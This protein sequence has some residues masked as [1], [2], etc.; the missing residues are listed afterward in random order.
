MKTIDIYYTRCFIR[1]HLTRNVPEKWSELSPRQFLT[2]ASLYRNQTADKRFF[3]RFLSL[4]GRALDM[5]DYLLYKL[6]ELCEFVNDIRKPFDRFYLHR[7]GNGLYEF[8]GKATWNGY[9]SILSVEAGVLPEFAVNA[10]LYVSDKKVE[11][12]YEF[13]A[14]RTTAGGVAL[15]EKD[16][17]SF[18]VLRFRRLRKDRGL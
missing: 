9:L 2:V 6:S 7:I 5:P 18:K 4:P 1:H 3:K 14:I 8:S 15:V 11:N 10:G 17:T 13:P 16:D 12:T